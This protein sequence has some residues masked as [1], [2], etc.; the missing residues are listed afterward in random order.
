V[1]VAHT[2]SRRGCVRAA[3]GRTGRAAR[4]GK[5]RAVAQFGRAPVS[6]T[7]GRGFESLPPC[8]RPTT[9]Q[10]SEPSGLP[11][12]SPWTLFATWTLMSLKTFFL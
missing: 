4:L 8:F 10:A 12:T 7:G 2:P 11:T 3:W 5:P 9:V 6:K 1:G